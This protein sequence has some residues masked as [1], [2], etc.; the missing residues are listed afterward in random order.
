MYKQGVIVNI[1]YIY[2]KNAKEN[3]VAKLATGSI[4]GLAQGVAA[5]SQVV[6]HT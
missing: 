6:A 5:V 2:Y 1:V 3:I 4:V